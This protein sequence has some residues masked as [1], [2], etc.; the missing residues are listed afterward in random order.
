MV[1]K[2]GSNT[3]SGSPIYDHY[4]HYTPADN[5]DAVDTYSHVE[6]TSIVGVQTGDPYAHTCHHWRG[7]A[8]MNWA[9][10]ERQAQCNINIRFTLL[11]GNT[12]VLTD[13]C[14]GSGAFGNLYPA[15]IGPVVFTDSANPVPKVDGNTLP[16]T[17]EVE[18]ASLDSGGEIVSYAISA[19][20]DCDASPTVVVY[21]GPASGSTFPV[22]D[23]LVTIRATDNQN[24]IGDGILTVRVTLPPDSD[25]DGL[26]DYEEASLGTGECRL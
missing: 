8:R 20:D 19:G 21:Q 11:A 15:V 25:S 13:G 22:G 7:D 10:Y 23:T 24:N 1:L 2:P 4:S 16:Y 3:Y 14:T 17:L 12:A 9:V 5:V 6:S 26:S 18:A